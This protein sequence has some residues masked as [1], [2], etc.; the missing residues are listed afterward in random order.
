[1][2]CS[3]TGRESSEKITISTPYAMTGRNYFQKHSQNAGSVINCFKLV[4]IQF[5]LI[6]HPQ[7]I[8]VEYVKCLYRQNS[9]EHSPQ[10]NS[11]RIYIYSF[12]ERK[13]GKGR[14]ARD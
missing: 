10:L 1:M 5:V 11:V 13:E 8:S 3:V 12:K 4:Q 6:Q 7:A 9:S 14:A 2:A